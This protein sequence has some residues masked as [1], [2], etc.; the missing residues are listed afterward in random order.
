M[1]IRSQTKRTYLLVEING[2]LKIHIL[3]RY[4]IYRHTVCALKTE[5]KARLL[6]TTNIYIL[7]NYVYMKLKH[8][9]VIILE[10]HHH[11]KS[12]NDYVGQ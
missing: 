10:A 7:L 4:H 3:S 6:G 11:S 8:F 12:Q 5:S 9:N 2:N 1:I